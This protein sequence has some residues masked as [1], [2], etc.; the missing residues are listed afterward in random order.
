MDHSGKQP[1][2]EIQP[3]IEQRPL[4]SP[5]TQSFFQKW[6]EINDSIVPQIVNRQ[7]WE[8]RDIKGVLEK[9]LGGKQTLFLPEDLQ[10]WEMV[11]VMEVVDRDTFMAKPERQ[12]EK[13][14][15][16]IALGKLFQNSGSYIAQRLNSIEQGREIACALAEEFYEYGL[17]LKNG[18]RSEQPP[19]FDA[20]LSR[21]L[22]SE[23]IK[24]VD[25]FLAGEKLYTTRQA[26]AEKLGA[27]NPTK[28][29]E[30]YEAERQKTLAQFFR[31][32]QKTFDLKREAKDNELKTDTE[33][34]KPWQR[35][36]PIHSAFW[37]KIE[38]AMAKE[39][40][41]P[42]R[43][44]ESAIFR[45]GLEKL[46]G[47][48]KESKSRWR[49]NINSLFEKLGI[50]I[51]IEQRKITDALNIA[52]LRTELEAIRQTKDV[53]KISAKEREIA[54][55]I[56]K[57]VSGFPY[58]PDANNPAEMVAN[59]YINCVGAS[60]LG[61]ALMKEAGLRYL[62]GFV[63]EH[64][65]LFLITEDGHVEWRDM[66]NVAFN[67]NLTDGMIV[68]KTQDGLPLT[69]ADITAFSHN[70]KP[71]G[72]MFDIESSKYQE[73]L[74]WVK[75]GQRQ[76]VAIFEP[77]YGQQAQVLCNTG[78]ALV[79]LGRHKEAI[80]AYQQAVAIDPKQTYAYYGLG[81]ALDTLGRHKEAI[82]AYQQAV[83]ID[84]KFVHAYNA[85]GNALDTLGRHKEAIE[86]YQKFIS[87]ANKR[88][89]AYWIKRA[90]TIIATL[91]NK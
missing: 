77:E 44:F 38:K 87:L 53:S 11:G 88:E 20:V 12:N 86:A 70:P 65:I 63:P 13:K 42:K 37:T 52:K 49:H 89:D 26:R 50:N 79:T 55:K 43:E 23:E 59:Q 24:E 45:R 48:M 57:A 1:K 51:Q 72:L 60:T 29:D 81:N 30:L 82:E 22:S 27:A 36:A 21:N 25:R 4:E 56:Q 19:I 68:G 34:L 17:S 71:E 7:S 3:I 67:E 83:A 73:K 90:E 8:Q 74:R 35:Y 32:A 40:E 85:L 6:C 80:E 76:F 31:T 41:A 33:H 46:V 75:E 64:S 5:A 61:G 14:D 78:N 69:V 16:L 15:K 84:P 66:L 47:E 58:K 91:R 9:R 2:F 28:R 10:L 18:R 62:V 54:N 39:V